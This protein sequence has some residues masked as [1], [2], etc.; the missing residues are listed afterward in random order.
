LP[1]P[2]RTSPTAFP[3]PHG[4]L[5]TE[6]LWVV[7]PTFDEADNIAGAVGAVLAALTLLAADPHVLVVDDAS[8]DGTGAIAEAIA[9]DDPRVHV[10]HREAKR[11]LGTAYLDGFKLALE[12]G[13]AHVLEMDADG[14]HDPADLGRLIA[15]T[16]HADLVLGS[17][18]VAR[19][20]VEGW[21]VVR[22]LVSRGGSWYARRLLGLRVRDLTGGFKCF[23]REVLEAIDLDTVRCEGYA[24]Q[25]ELTHRA[26]RAGFRVAEVPITFRDRVAGE[27][28]M[29]WRIAIEAVVVVPRLALAARGG[30]RQ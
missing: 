30:S 23:R 2:T 15:A 4:S 18:Y 25:I 6:P 24:F 11:G 21:G 19:G 26:V 17:R 9:A 3:R 8:P 27:S 28:K 1:D 10:L 7:L 5:L 29:S 13:A 14:S 16:R 20:R 22:H 12:A